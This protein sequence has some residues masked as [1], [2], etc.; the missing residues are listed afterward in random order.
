MDHKINVLLE[1]ADSYLNK[2][3]E[4][5]QKPEE[6][7]VPYSICKNANEAILNYLSSFLLSNAREIPQ[8]RSIKDLL[9]I[10]REVESEFNNLHLSPFYNPAETEDLWMN[11]DMASDFLTMAETTRE[12]VYP[13]IK[14]QKTY[15]Q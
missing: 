12:M 7:V 11:I 1:R 13:Y 4:E 15:V 10:C 3:K 9:L 2:A 5:F 6:D 14:T 8:S